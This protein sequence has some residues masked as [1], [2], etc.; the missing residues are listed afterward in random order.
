MTAGITAET[1]HETVRAHYAGA[2]VAASQG[3][4]CC[5]DDEAIGPALYG[6]LERAELPDA[7]VR[8]YFAQDLSAADQGVIAATQIPWYIACLTDKVTHAA[9]A[10]RLE[11]V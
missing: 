11:H 3:V 2:A 6:A 8:Q 9:S 7:A 1:I 4:A 5:G 10:R